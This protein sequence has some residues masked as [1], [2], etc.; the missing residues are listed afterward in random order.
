MGTD[1]S[2][3]QILE[4]TRQL[5]EVKKAEYQVKAA[6]EKEGKGLD[7]AGAGDDSE[8]T[9]GHALGSEQPAAPSV[10]KEPLI[11]GDANAEPEAGGSGTPES[12]NPGKGEDENNETDRSGTLGSEDPAPVSVTKKPAIS[13]D[14]NAKVA[15]D[16][17][18]KLGNEILGDIR[19]Y[20]A[21]QKPEGDEK[22][23]EKSDAEKSD[24]EKPEAEKSE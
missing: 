7:T 18:A 12:A 1:A 15:D 20:Q 8:K 11:S 21:E 10:K 2:L 13:G 9:R 24:A 5:V 4:D 6:E 17:L 16:E 14:A 23:G 3:R 22:A 19:A